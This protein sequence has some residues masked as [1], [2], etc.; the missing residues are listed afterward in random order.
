MLAFLSSV[1]SGDLGRAT[2]YL[3]I[4]QLPATARGAKAASAARALGNLLSEAPDFD[5]GAVSNVPEGNLD[6]GLPE[7]RE[8]LYNP[9]GFKV[10]M[11]RRPEGGLS[12]WVFTPSTVDSVLSATPQPDSALEQ[13][14]PDWI[15]Q[16]RFLGTPA[17]RWIALAVL[18][19]IA[20]AI[21]RLLAALIMRLLSPACKRLDPLGTCNI[22]GTFIGP[23]RAFIALVV[24]RSVAAWIPLSSLGRFYVE[25]VLSVATLLL[26]I[27][28][29]SRILDFVVARIR[30]AL[31]AQHASLSLSVLPLI[32]RLAK[33]I[34]FVFAVT[35]TLANW[36]FDMTT[37]LA[38]VGIGGIAIALAAQ[39]TVENLF[40]GIAIITDAPVSVGD[41][42]KFGDRVGTVEDIGLRSTQVRTLD[43]TLV[44]IPNGEFS[45]MMLEN[46]SRRDKVWFHHTLNL[47]K[48][49]AP[50]QVRT[51]MAEIE[52]LLRS[53]PKVEVGSMPVRFVGGTASLDI[54]IFAYVQ[55]SDYNEYL[56]IQQDLLLPMMEAVERIS[57]PPE[58]AGRR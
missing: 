45:S 5:I 51:I 2:E 54:E 16:W 23:L 36:G 4:T 52:D 50:D 3:D 39:K 1:R 35:F 43:R 38:G 27:W 7:S 6:D 31:R 22:P 46:F 33:G 10:E 19:P 56:R 17:W 28:F 24:F 8:L 12:I 15:T 32:S 26:A 58:M 53:N 55:T 37:V 48:D 30:L 18:L 34:L 42:C 57:A 20:L 11:E 9:R 40:G 25:R 13:R 49:T 44:T 14:L 29:G 41:F 47:K 21:G